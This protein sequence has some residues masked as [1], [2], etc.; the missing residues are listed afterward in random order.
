MVL[1]DTYSC[2]MYRLVSEGLFTDRSVANFLHNLMQS[3][4]LAEHCVQVAGGLMEIS[5]LKQLLVVAFQGLLAVI[6][7]GIQ[8]QCCINKVFRSVLRTAK[9]F[10]YQNHTA[11][12]AVYKSAILQSLSLASFP[13]PPP[14]PAFPNYK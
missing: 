3:L 2:G 1:V 5:S 14:P 9:V 11:N 6:L 12:H 4:A 8:F 10:N 7:S 13:A